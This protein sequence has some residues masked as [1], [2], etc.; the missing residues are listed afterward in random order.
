MLFVT[1]VFNFGYGKS[2]DRSGWKIAYPGSFNI[3]SDL[4][5]RFCK[6]HVDMVDDSHNQDK[7]EMKRINLAI[8]ETDL[9]NLIYQAGHD[10]A[11]FAELYRLHYEMVFRYCS[12]RLYNRHTAEDVTSTVFFKAMRK[13]HS[14]KGNPNDFRNWLYRIATNAI[15][16]YLRTA[17]KR[18]DAIHSVVQEY[19]SSHESSDQS[20]D[21]FEAV[22]RIIKQAVLRLSPK[23]QTVITLRYFEKMKLTEIA[24]ILASKPATIRGRLSRALDALRKEL[25]AVPR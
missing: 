15:N 16:D 2:G 9:T 1:C 5:Q 14:F 3:L 7:A 17:Q 22:N 24:G 25:K 8:S 11:A 10:S 12:R 6:I 21:D 18:S 4:A 19:G 13:I 23:Y 20:D